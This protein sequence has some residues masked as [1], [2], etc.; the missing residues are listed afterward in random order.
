M[1][2]SSIMLFALDSSSSSLIK[3][4]RILRAFRLLRVVEKISYLQQ[5]VVAVSMSIIP[6]L[7]AL[8]RHPSS[9]CSEA[10]RA[11]LQRSHPCSREP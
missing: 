5:L 1:V 2:V 3:Q 6:A 7:Q 11:S 9:N 10:Q 4:M 8:V